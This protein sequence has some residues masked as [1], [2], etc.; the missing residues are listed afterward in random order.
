MPVFTFL[1]LSLGVLGRIYS[2]RKVQV[3]TRGRLRSISLSGSSFWWT[4][5]FLG[6][7]PKSSCG[8][9][10]GKDWFCQ[11]GRWVEFRHVY[12]GELSQFSEIHILMA[13]HE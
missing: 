7:F 9:P 5:Q 3:G 4:P 10:I 2:Y 13:I 12:F 8:S 1:V 6:H 11:L